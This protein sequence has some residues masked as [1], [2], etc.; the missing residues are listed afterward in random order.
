MITLIRGTRILSPATGAL[1]AADVLVH[2]GR[3]AA[4]GMDLPD[5]AVDR[6]VDGRDHIALPGLIN[7]HTHGHNNLSR[8][9]ARRWSLED[10]LNEGVALQAGRTVEDQ[11]L[12]AALG[13]LEM[14]RSGCTAAY[15]LFMALP[16]PTAEGIEAVVRAYTDVGLRAVLAPAVSDIVFYRT[17]PDLLDILPVDL[18]RTVEGLRA[19]AADELLSMSESAF[20]RWDGFA[21]GRIR[22]GFAP[23]IPGQCTDE[24]L[25]GFSRLVREYNAPIHTH[26]AESKVQVVHAEQRWGTT[27]TRH[28]AD[29][30]LLGE[31]FTGAH[32]IWLTEEDID[33]LARAGATIAH[34]PASN[35]RLGAGIA[36]VAE[37][38]E[39]GLAVGLGTDG[40]LS[41]DNQNMFESMRYAALVSRVRAPYQQERWIDGPASWHMATLGSARVLGLT[42]DA[43]AIAPGR[44]ADI[45]LLRD[46]SVSLRPL[47][48]ALNALVFAE[49]GASVQTVLIDGTVVMENGRVLTVDEG[50]LLTRAQEAADRLRHGAPEAEVL[51]NR[52]SPYIRQACRAAVE[53]P[54]PINRFAASVGH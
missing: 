39:S 45:V 32:G 52:L 43:G 22:M 9:M 48:D 11:Y 29:V 5:T 28:L 24:L 19:P 51:A 8:G 26:L 30:G 7:A 49:T 13:A 6:A 4:V 33:L 50:A 42:A 27:P 3:I 40:S 20:L 25:H 12:S 44:K 31:R 23:T 35:L 16:F 38:L 2:D 53:R 18:R 14:L 21:G 37:L 34:N 41:S 1:E 15:D 10:Q 54:S 46:A 36:P 17:V 47:N